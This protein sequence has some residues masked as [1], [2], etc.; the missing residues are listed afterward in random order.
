ME[1]LDA[2]MAIRLLKSN[3]KTPVKRQKKATPNKTKDKEPSKNRNSA[4]FQ[5]QHLSSE[6]EAVIG[7]EKSSRPQVVKQLWTYIKDN[8]LQNPDDKRQ[9][10][11]DAKLQELFKKS[12]FFFDL[13]HLNNYAYCVSLGQTS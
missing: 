2:L 5:E 4:F 3:L 8:N 10:L 6:L 9:I 13:S 12:K 7:V 1:K 11:C